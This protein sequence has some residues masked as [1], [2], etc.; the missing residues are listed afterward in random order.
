MCT[1]YFQDYAGLGHCIAKRARITRKR[2]Y[3]LGKDTESS[4]MVSMVGC[5][6]RAPCISYGEAMQGPGSVGRTCGRARD[7]KRDSRID[8]SRQ[9]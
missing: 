1:A 2:N 9:T 7:I 4:D 5:P 8:L 6:E 3:A